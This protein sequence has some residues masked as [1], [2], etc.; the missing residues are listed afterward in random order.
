MPRPPHPEPGGR[1]VSSGQRPAIS[2]KS[3]S[4]FASPMDRLLPST[5]WLRKW[6]NS[7][8]GSKWRFPFS[9]GQRRSNSN[10]GRSK[11]SADR[12]L[13]H[14]GRPL[15]AG[16]LT[17]TA[18]KTA[19]E[20]N[21]QE[22]RRLH[23]IASAGGTGKSVSADRSSARSARPQHHGILQGLQCGHAEHGAGLARSGG[24]HRL[25]RTSPSPSR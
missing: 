25:S 5:V 13:N 4:R 9:A 23:Q 3:A 22:S 2:S 24:D 17:S 20:R 12:S 7:G 8:R 16:P 6:T 14:G 11:R 18:R 19:R 15:E 21:G 1:K 10:M